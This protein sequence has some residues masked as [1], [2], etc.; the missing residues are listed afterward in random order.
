M[1]HFGE[2]CRRYAPL[3]ICLLILDSFFSLLLWI[4]DAE[5]QGRLTGLILLAS[6]I[7]F[8]LIILILHLKEMQK[9]ALFQDFLTEP[10][11]IHTENSRGT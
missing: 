8:A 6:I 3:L 11:E 10:D 2:T 1:K 4:S 7:F 5:A 9:K